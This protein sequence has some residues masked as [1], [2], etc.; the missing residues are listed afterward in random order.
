M[1]R[2]SRNKIQRGPYSEVAI[3]NRSRGGHDAIRYRALHATIASSRVRLVCYRLLDIVAV[4]SATYLT[5]VI[6]IKPWA[7]TEFPH[8]V[9]TISKETLTYEFAVICRCYSDARL[10][11]RSITASKPTPS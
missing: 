10:T 8:R 3:P 1:S 6:S 9:R 7:P 5:T 2:N 4:G 11:P